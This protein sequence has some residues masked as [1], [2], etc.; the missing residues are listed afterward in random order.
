M[1]Q[2][3]YFGKGDNLSGPRLL[4]QSGLWSIFVQT[5]MSASAVIIRKIAFKHAV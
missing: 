1:M 3:A 4:N 5:Q 2:S